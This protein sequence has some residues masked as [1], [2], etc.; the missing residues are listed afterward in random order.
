MKKCTTPIPTDAHQHP[1]SRAIKKFWMVTVRNINKIG[2]YYRELFLYKQ[3][4]GWQAIVP[5]IGKGSRFYWN[6]SPSPYF[7][8]FYEYHIKMNIHCFTEWWLA[9]WPTGNIVDLPWW[10]CLLSSS[11]VVQ[12]HCKRK[13]IL[14]TRARSL[15]RH[16]GCDVTDGLSA[17]MAARG[18]TKPWKT[19][20]FNGG[21]L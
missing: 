19:V 5:A 13:W 10:F 9:L 7:L 18:S 3:D 21:T 6:T 15:W 1:I 4:L 17:I 2:A 11:L 20:P 14:F 16:N 8:F 12:H